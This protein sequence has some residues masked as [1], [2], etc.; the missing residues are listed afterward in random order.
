MKKIVIAL[1]VLAM[2]IMV[3]GC[4]STETP[5]G[6]TGNPSTT[7]S[8]V[9]TTDDTES[10]GINLSE[11]K[12]GD[13]IAIVGQVAGSK[14]VNGNTLWVQVKQDDGSFVI[15]HCQMKQEFIEA[16][17]SLATLDVV[18]IDGLFL[19]YADMEMENTS[20]LVTLYDCEIK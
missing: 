13:V 9:N 16:A 2:M 14:L 12:Q 5:I 19:S 8:G 17:E 1:L 3:A 18:K 7:E 4:D 11:C 15:Y 20:P 10:D 6:D